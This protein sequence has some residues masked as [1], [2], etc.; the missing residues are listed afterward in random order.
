[1]T[2]NNEW[3]RGA[4]FYQIYPRSFYDSNNDG[5]GDI[6]GIT[7]KL[8][9]I[10]DLGVDALWI[11][12]ML[13]SPM[14]DFGYDVSDYR[15]IDP[16]FG[17]MADFDAMIEKAHSLGLKV[18]I[19][20][21]LSHTSNEH[22]WFIESR[23]SKDN[24]KADWYV[25]A[26]A[27]PDGTPPNNWRSL[28]GGEAWAF[29]TRR[30]QFYMHNFLTEQPDLNYHNPEVQDEALDILKFWLDRGVDGFR[31]DVINFLF[32]DEQ[33]RNNPPRTGDENIFATQYE[34][35]D[36]YSM[37]QHIYD[38]SRPEN[39]EFMKR[40]RKLMDQYPG[41]MTLGEIGDDDSTAAAA[42]YTSN[43][44]KLNTAYEF[45]LLTGNDI[46][47]PK[48]EEAVMSF[49]NQPEAG[50]P[51]WAFCNHD[52]IRVTSRWGDKINQA[53]N[54][55]FAK[56]LFSILTTL[57]GTIFM[58]QGEELGLTNAKID[59]EDIQDPWGKYLWPEWQGRDGCRTP[60]PWDGSSDMAGFNSGTKTWLPIPQ[61]HKDNAVAQQQGSDNSV[62]EA[63][64]ALLAWRKEHD[65]FQT[66]HI[67]FINTGDELILHYARGSE[68][69]FIDCV[70]N[71]SNEEK[72]LNIDRDHEQS[73]LFSN[74]ADYDATT[75]NV[76][77]AA[78]GYAFLK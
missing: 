49:Y 39:I 69:D 61:D 41:T 75:Q 11:S 16:L 30:E 8:D 74:N 76:T 24:P 4:V 50:W 44:D 10:A 29:E 7:Q 54:P 78:F 67:R 56:V 53:G 59:F 37:Q 2:N 31:L 51:A 15:D 68:D 55:D 73:L 60:F 70:F 43:D 40:L 25:W 42:L 47:A 33:L 52:V 12:P 9:Y 19:D 13:K 1:M 17:T 71:L 26:E 66:G 6:P 14:K 65:L 22:P 35:K 20:M 21:I 3:W 27:S 58:Y 64:K 72:H 34:K 23:S 77:L 18:I 32:H 36:P 45:A 28:F 48:V 46:T 5:I 57:R 63:A 62:L 38:K